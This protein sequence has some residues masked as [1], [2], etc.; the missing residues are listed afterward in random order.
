MQEMFIARK[1]VMMTPKKRLNILLADD[2]SQHAQAAIEL[3]QD[4]PIPTK[5]HIAVLRAF[6]S[7]QIASIA[8]FEASLARSKSQL[9]GRDFHVDTELKLGSAAALIL[10]KAVT[11]NVDLIVLGAKGLRSTVSILLGGVAQH[12]LE[13]AP[14]P[15]LIVRA[16]YRGFKK[17]LMVTDGSSSSLSAARY[18]GKFPL[19]P[20]IDVH[21]MHVLPPIE[22]PVMM[23]PYYGGWQMVYAMYPT[24]EEE[25][26][27]RKKDAKTG[28]ALLK[29]TSSPLKRNGIESTPVLVRGD[30]A[31]EIMDYVKTEKIDLIVAGSRGLSNLKS[32]WVGSVSRKLVHYSD[33]SVLIVKR[34][35]KE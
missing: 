20:K 29:R 18:L 13:H 30:A 32:I 1:E 31:T 3:L 28:E 2:G 22:V 11:N 17:I 16:P 4:I 19:P 21:V 15:V 35:G 34:P 26:L 10:D 27:I 6:N 12:V 7:G 14:C 33:C 8:E 24:R 5:S 25:A 23:E 9:A